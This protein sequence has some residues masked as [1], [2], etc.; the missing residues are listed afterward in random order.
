MSKGGSYEDYDTLYSEIIQICP[1]DCLNFTIYDSTGDGL[2]HGYGYLDGSY[3][4]Y[5]SD[6]L[7][8]KGGDDFGFKEST[9]HFG[10]GCL[11]DVAS[12]LFGA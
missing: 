1:G 12:K 9:A 3:K 11:S 10:I 2:L 7:V 6:Q 5:Y 8:I 4:V